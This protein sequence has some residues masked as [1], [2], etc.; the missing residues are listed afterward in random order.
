MRHKQG[1]MFSVTATSF[2]MME[3]QS[4]SDTSTKSQSPV[5]RMS[6]DV[7]N[8]NKPCSACR[9]RKV[10]CDKSQPCNN[11]IRHGVSCVYD[12]AKESVVSQQMLQERVERLERMV[13][14]MAAFAL[15]S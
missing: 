11:C 8:L 15:F 5:A 10:R 2:L 12:A 7:P 13:E 1:L 6:S 3:S 4:P 9:R 14:D